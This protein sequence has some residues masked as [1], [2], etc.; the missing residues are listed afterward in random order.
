MGC[1]GKSVVVREHCQYH[2]ST[3]VEDQVGRMELIRYHE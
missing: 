2:W 1:E 3:G